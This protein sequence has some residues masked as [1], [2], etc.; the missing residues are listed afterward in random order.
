MG[1]FTNFLLALALTVVIEGLVMLVM[2][3][4][5]QWVRYNL[6][7]NIVTNPLLQVIVRIILLF[8]R[9]DYGYIYKPGSKTGLAAAVG[10]V[11]G[12][13][14]KGDLGYTAIVLVGELIVL[15]AE[16]LLYRA[17]TGEKFG[18]CFVRSLVTNALSFIAGIVL[19]LVGFW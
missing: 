6:Y 7:C 17:M 12:T 1:L 9:L 2:T 19:S 13:Y 15:F 18:R 11:F 16:A 10:L 5:L 8:Y 4:S 14:F 3:R